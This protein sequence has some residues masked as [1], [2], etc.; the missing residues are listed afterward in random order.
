LPRNESGK[1]MRSALAARIKM[2]K[3]DS[4]TLSADDDTLT[5]DGQDS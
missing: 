2:F 3:E 1:V 4:M 5:D